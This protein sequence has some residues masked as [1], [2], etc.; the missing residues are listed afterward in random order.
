LQEHQLPEILRVGLEDIVLRILTLDLGEPSKFL[1]SAIDPPSALAM[2]NA[3]RLLESLGA[4]ECAWTSPH[5]LTDKTSAA[6]GNS[7]CGEL[8]ASTELTALG[9]HLSSLPVDPRI[10]KM[11]IYGAL[12]G[13]VDSA[14]TIAAAMTCT[15]PL[16][17]APF[18]QRDAANEARVSMSVEGSDHLTLLG[19]FNEWKHLRK[20]KGAKS[21]Q[22]F[23]NNNF[24]SRTTLFQMEDLRRHYAGLLAEIGFLP[25]G[26]KL[27]NAGHHSATPGDT[28]P[29]SRALLR[30]LLCAGL[31]PNVIVCPRSLVAG[32]G[33]ETAGDVTFRS[34]SKGDV[35]LHP[36]TVSFSAKKLSSRYFC[37]YE[38][39]RTSKL[40]VRDLTAVNP[41]AL[42]LFGGAIEDYPREG[43]ITIDDWLRFRVTSKPARS[44]CVPARRI[45][46]IKHLR[47]QLESML[48]RKIVSPA[49]NDT[50]S[51]PIID[52]ITGLLREE[53]P[54]VFQSEELE[55]IPPFN[56]APAQAS[57]SPG[58]PVGYHSD[59]RGRS[60]GRGRSNGSD[61][62]RTS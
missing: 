56:L 41:L 45:A 32:P 16:F 48:L 58:R 43:V 31:Y 13:C 5:L 59:R 21:A 10:G 18:D 29:G 49:S 4:V 7:P 57:D 9:F 6:L 1:A 27:A 40:F 38:I 61:N 3:L 34:Q 50:D 2:K 28:G 46:L 26:F 25:K 35:Y 19:A 60:R 53:D 52:A 24:L 62:K 33:Q 12:F 51:G 44:D 30:A 11:M 42:L 8:D 14:L 54:N 17:A 47:F 36:C 20:V 55:M 22:I 15:K 39:V 23:A 37:F